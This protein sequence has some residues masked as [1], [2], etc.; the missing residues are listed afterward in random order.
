MMIYQ[1]TMA[2]IWLWLIVSG[3]IFTVP[4]FTQ[5]IEEDFG[6]EQDTIQTHKQISPPL[7]RLW[8]IPD[9]EARVGYLFHFDVPADAFEGVI[10]KYAAT[11]VGDAKLPSWLQFDS[12]NGVLEGVPSDEDKGHIVLVNFTAIGNN[13]VDSAKDLFA[14]DVLPHT[15]T[16]HGISPKEKCKSGE[17]VTTLSIVLDKDFNEITPKNKITLLKNL[18]GFLGFKYERLSILPQN[19]DILSNSVILAG[20]GNV[21]KQKHK[22]STAVIWQVGC[23][24]NIDLNYKTQI[25]QIKDNTCDGTLSEV[26]QL[27]VIGWHVMRQSATKPFRHRRQVVGSGDSEIGETTIDDLEEDTENEADLEAEGEPEQRVVVSMASPRFPEPTVTPSA[28]VHHHR[29]HHGEVDGVQ[30]TSTYSTPVLLTSPVPYGSIMPTP[31]YIPERPSVYS[32]A[33]TVFPSSYVDASV[34]P[35]PTFQIEPSATPEMS[36]T[37][38]TEPLPID[39]STERHISESPTTPLTPELTTNQEEIEYGPK[40]LKPNIVHKL[41]KQAVTAGKPFRYV[42]PESVFSDVEDGNTRKLRLIFKTQEGTSVAPLSWIQFNPENQEVYALPLEEHVSRWVFIVEAMDKE[43]ES[44]QDKLEISVQHHKGRRTVTH[45]FTLELILLTPHEFA[46]PVDWQLLLVDK[47]ASLYGD[48]DVSAITVLGAN[49]SSNPITFTWTNDSLPRSHCPREEINVLLK[50]LKAK[51]DGTPTDALKAALAPQLKIEKVKWFGKGPCEATPAPPP[52]TKNYS[53]A[54]RNQVDLLNATVGELLVY[55]VPE[56]SFYDP[57][58]GSAR[59]MKLS[60][61][62]MDRTQVPPNNWLQFDSKNQEFYGIPMPSNV[63]HAEYQLVCTDSGG[64][65]ANDGLVVKVY[66]AA[67]T[68]YNVEFSMSLGIDFND[69]TQSPATQ[70]HFIEK[71]AELFGDRDTSSIVIS[72]IA[73]NPTLVTWHNRSLPTD[74][75]PHD[76][77]KRLR[78]TL[79]DD[80]RVSVRASTVLGPEFTVVD[81]RLTPIGIC[82]GSLTEIH[83][84]VEIP[85]IPDDVHPVSRSD[86]YLVTVVV[87]AVV[88]A[89]MLVC[90]GLVACALYRRRRTGKMSVGSEDERQSFRSKGIPVIFQDEL[91]ERPEPANKSPVIMKEEKPPLPPPEYHQRTALLADTDHEDSPYQPPPPFA[92]SRDSARPKP[93]P[94]YRM[95]PPYVPP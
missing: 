30:P 41:P 55:R 81:A 64:L 2:L 90:A 83:P 58:D 28:D 15:F 42:I 33:D 20:P 62:T 87:P 93:T 18:A 16:Q 32:T 23:N 69:F 26:V 40:N 39:I 48:P 27:Q 21:K 80:D 9:T 43:G 75:C 91:E 84:A 47:L 73:P 22:T 6:F 36:T 53:P 24:G 34:V 61:L 10:S 78:E 56:D 35:T 89:G 50:V 1:M 7:R 57:E 92:S 68:Q 82:Q 67:K 19:N 77:I 79:I 44:N 76:T 54:P 5:D 25:K 60:L 12:T 88:I 4:V 70:R 51:E 94:T 46:S 14:I 8:G 72:G 85:P 63:G 37:Q 13:H 86:E 66:P 95:P 49:P 38:E 71:L 52:S 11:T 59:Y 31:T 74:S 45:Q 17:R 29:H 65:T 3:A